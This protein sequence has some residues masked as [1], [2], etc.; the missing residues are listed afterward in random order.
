MLCAVY[1]TNKKSGMYL[2]VPKKGHFEDVPEALMSRFG[3]PE[4][5]TIIALEKRER[6]G[7][8]DKEKLIDALNEQGFYLQMPPKEDNLLEKHRESLG[9]SKTP[10]K[11]F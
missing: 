7:G 10:D 3:V 4:L 9:L 2:Y 8:V 11:K 5:V 1:K 6:L